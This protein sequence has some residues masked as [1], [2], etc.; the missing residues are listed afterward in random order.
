MKELKFVLHFMWNISFITKD[1][2]IA[3]CWTTMKYVQW[4]NNKYSRIQVIGNA[5]KQ[6]G[7]NKTTRVQNNVKWQFYIFWN[8]SN[9]RKH[10]MQ[11]L[12]CGQYP[13]AINVKDLAQ[14]HFFPI[15]AHVARKMCKRFSHV[16]FALV[17]LM[18]KEI[19]RQPESDESSTI[20]TVTRLARTNQFSMQ[21]DG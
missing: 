12:L 19:I 2:N 14:D 4:K 16:S 18:W 3:S 10:S 8:E 11:E 15:W 5:I 1:K 17:G 6:G 13:Y 9:D 20:H 7:C 21:N